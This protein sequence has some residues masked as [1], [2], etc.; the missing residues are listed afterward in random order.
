LVAAGD[1]QAAQLPAPGAAAARVAGSSDSVVA[2]ELASVRP[3]GDAAALNGAHAAHMADTAVLL[4]AG[5]E[6]EAQ[7][8]NKAA[9]PP[10]DSSVT[11]SSVST[12]YSHGDSIGSHSLAAAAA[13][14]VS[15]SAGLPLGDARADAT[16]R[17]A[18]AEPVF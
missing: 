6:A 9:L 5:E 3:L 7:L 16:G 4:L 12:G 13:F 17:A 14:K 15:P 10:S 8:G 11:L 2:V 1:K 18:F